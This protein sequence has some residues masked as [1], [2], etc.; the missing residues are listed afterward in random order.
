VRCVCGYC[1][2][3]RAIG[4]LDSRGE[5]GGSAGENRDALTQALPSLA[6][7]LLC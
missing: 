2:G 7:L 5:A 3:L 6:P 1:L 4:G